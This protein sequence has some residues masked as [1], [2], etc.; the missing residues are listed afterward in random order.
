MIY[1]LKHIGFQALTLLYALFFVVYPFAHVHYHAGQGMQICYQ[2]RLHA[3]PEWRTGADCECDHLQGDFKHIA[4]SN[5]NLFFIAVPS[6]QRTLCPIFPESRLIPHKT[7]LLSSHTP[8]QA[9]NKS[10]PA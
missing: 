6:S 10:P 9:P 3:T 7:F 8:L 5:P 1:R 4:N 2:T